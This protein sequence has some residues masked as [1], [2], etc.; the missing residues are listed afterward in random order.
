MVRD[1]LLAEIPTV[2]HA[3]LYAVAAIAA[4]AVVVIGDAL[5]LPAFPMAMVALIFCFWLRVMAIRHG[6]RL[7]VAKFRGQGNSNVAEGVSKDREK[8]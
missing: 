2:L 8:P 5:K 3:E 6:W 4:A 7:P 1:I